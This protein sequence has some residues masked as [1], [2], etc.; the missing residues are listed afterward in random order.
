MTKANWEEI[1]ADL[2]D[3]AFERLKVGNILRFKNKDGGETELK[4]MKLNKKSKKCFVQPVKTFTPE[5]LDGTVSVVED[6][7]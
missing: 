2:T 1:G 7:A 6:A 5:E 4:I 3:E